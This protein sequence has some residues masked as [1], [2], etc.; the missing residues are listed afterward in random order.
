M[1]RHRI[2][3]IIVTIIILAYAGLR[4]FAPP[5]LSKTHFG[6]AYYDRDGRLL[7]LTLSMDEKY[8]IF[9]P[10]SEINKS[11]IDATIL[12]E[13]KYFR[14]H[15]G[16]NPIA[17]T[18][19]T[20]KHF[21]KSGRSIGAS[22]IT[23]Q[24]ARLRYNLDTKTPA[25]KFKQVLYAIYLDFA[26]SKND[27]LEAYL[28]LAPYGGNIEG[29]GAASLI[30]FGGRAN[31][32]SQIESITLS[33][34]PQ[35]PTKR[36]L[37]TARG[38]QNI[39]NM[40]S[41]LVKRWVA[42]YPADAEKLSILSEMPLHVNRVSDL[43]FHAPHFIDREISRNTNYW[44]D[45]GDTNSEITTTLDLD[46]QKKL[47]RTLSDAVLKNKHM[48]VN[49]AAAVLV[50]Y[51]TMQVISHIGSVNY[52]D[53]NIL[54][55]NDGVHAR[56]SP[57]S[58]LKPFIYAYAAD[59]G[60]I[61][62]M[63]LLKDAAVNFGVYAPENADNEFYGPVLARD[64]LTHSRNI[65]AIDLVRKIGT[66]N[67]YKFL[68][69]AG[70]LGLRDPSHYG[71]S[72]ALGGAELS[73]MELARLYA[74]MANLGTIHEIKTTMNADAKDPVSL[75]SPEAFFLTL[76]MLGGQGDLTRRIPFAK[77]QTTRLNHYWKTGTS[78]SFRDAWT[79]GIFG[80]YVLI[81]WVGNFDGKPNNAF[82]G[83]KTAAP[84]Y[85]TL[86]NAIQ[87]YHDD[88]G[89]PIQNP[90]FYNDDLNISRVEMCAGVGGLAGV[91]C[92][93]ST[94]AYFIPGISPIETSS[95][96]RS[97]P[98]D[99]KTGRRSCSFNPE[100]TYMDTFEFWDPEYIDMFNSAGI[101]R[102]TP[103]PFVPGCDINV[104]Q[105]GQSAPMITSPIDR[106]KIVILSGKN[107]ENVSF[108]AISQT[109]NI[110]IF[111]FL[112]GAVIGT[113]TSGAIFQSHIP[114]GEY[115]LRAVD[116]MGN[117]SQIEFVVVK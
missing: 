106:T 44:R 6:R 49:N 76:D 96:Y 34:I 23:M 86:A 25:G 70:V 42:R 111:W 88:I 43:P 68:Q 90:N 80:D 57:G 13:D 109:P 113:T 2:F 78:S 46:L 1:R 77:K 115:T 110:K 84:I 40:R 29:I 107:S 17:L 114:M 14:Y 39:M 51:K 73:M 19:A 5:I 33:T 95:V 65:P 50:N 7:R 89:N 15:P 36:G 97:I 108:R 20:I 22:T 10:L 56:R 26:Y 41:D 93:K 100:T 35:N 82:S 37:T 45:I 32:L 75:L 74:G 27:I 8:R 71:I 52:F 58:T 9:T 38:M 85:F 28:N 59:M 81:V 55:E 62:G 72:I 47:E 112:N 61:H 101:K 94:M 53:K 11:F 54:G 12:Y 99:K 60:L 67:F 18:K 24:T 64:A 116:E 91:N 102:K 63:T 21:L 16:I 104:I 30:Y 105:F 4:L 31:D 69:T 79:A 87:N 92:P 83:A 117:V 3:C 103:P 48:G 98:I 66:V